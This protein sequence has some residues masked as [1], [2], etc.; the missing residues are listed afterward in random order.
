MQQITSDPA[1]DIQPKFS[2]DG[3]TIAFCSNRGGNWDIWTVQRDGTELRR[4]TTYAG[5]EISPTW[6]PDGQMIAFTLWS[7][8]ARRW[9]IWTLD[10]QQPGVRRFLTYG[11]FPNWSPDGSQIAFQRARQHGTRWY[12]I[13]TIDLLGHE[14]RH[15]TEIAYRPDAACIAPRWSPDGRALVYAAVGN[16]SQWVTDSRGEPKKQS[17]TEASLWV[18]NPRSGHQMQLAGDGSPAFNPAWGPTGRVF[19]V[20]KRDGLENIWSTGSGVS[21]RYAKQTPTRTAPVTAEINIPEPREQSRPVLVREDASR[22]ANQ[23]SA[24]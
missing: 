22:G 13:W 14:A 16:I 9:E 10:V 6:S 4:M 17:V 23:A 5:D 19:Y 7:P 3:S 24:P 21:G 8:R 12:S 15:P 2:P 11:M 20:A 18:T 1:D